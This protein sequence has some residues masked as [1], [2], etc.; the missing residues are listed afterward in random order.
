MC[1][2]CTNL[3]VCCRICKSCLLCEVLRSQNN[4]ERQWNFFFVFVGFG[5]RERV[6]AGQQGVQGVAVS[7]AVGTRS[8]SKISDEKLGNF[9]FVTQI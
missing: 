1:E 4:M 9:H 2:Y 5:E 6:P 8:R 7:S 3:K